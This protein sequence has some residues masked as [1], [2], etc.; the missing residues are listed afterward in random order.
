MRYIASQGP[1]DGKV[2]TIVDFWRMVVEQNINVIIMVANFV[3]MGKV[4]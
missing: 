3:E 4:C 1:K 2:S